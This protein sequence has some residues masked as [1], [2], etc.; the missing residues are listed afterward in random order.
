MTKIEKLMI[1]A[2]EAN[3]QALFQILQ[4]ISDQA[5]VEPQFDPV[6]TIRKAIQ[7]QTKSSQKLDKAKT[8]L[9]QKK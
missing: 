9:T 5:E 6:E 8:L 3:Q 4:S 7:L 1:E 2:Y